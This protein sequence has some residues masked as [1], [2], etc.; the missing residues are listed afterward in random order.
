MF[1]L[2]YIVVVDGVRP[3][4]CVS[5]SVIP[6]YGCYIRSV[7]PPVEIVVEVL[8]MFDTDIRLQCQTFHPRINLQICIAEDSP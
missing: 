3:C 2:E 6:S 7:Q 5:R 8:D 1:V 4:P